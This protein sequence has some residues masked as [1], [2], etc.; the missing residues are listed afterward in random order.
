[1]KPH[2]PAFYFLFLTVFTFKSNRSKVV[3]LLTHFLPPWLPTDDDNIIRSARVRKIEK[4]IA[5]D[6]NRVTKYSVEKGSAFLH[7]N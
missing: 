4:K 7:D 3:L 2:R 5:A 6:L 1:M